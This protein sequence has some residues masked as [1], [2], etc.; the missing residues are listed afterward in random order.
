MPF[1]DIDGASLEYAWI[2]GG[3]AA[4]PTIVFLHEGLGC[5][6]MWR[7]FPRRL[8]E[9][10]ACPALVYSRP[11]YGRSSGRLQRRGTDYLHIEALVVLP[12]VLAA[13]E[14]GEYLLF[15]HSDGASIALLHAASAA[16]PATGLIIEAPH[17]FV[18]DITLTGIRAAGE[19]YRGG[20][21]TWRN[22]LTRYHGAR[23]D[24]VFDAWHDVWL[25]PAFG[26]WN[27]EAELARI[28]CP[29]LLLQGEED[30]YG[31]RCQLDS[32]AER[33]D[34]PCETHL[35][36]DC[37]HVAHR[38]ASERVSQ[39]ALSFIRRLRCAL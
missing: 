26:D 16:V 11:G 5:V 34:G 3:D 12:R 30:E 13:L 23:T 39:L 19:A 21:G 33:T 8:A 36:P 4:A 31:S 38:D 10:S 17:V 25:N 6:E 27:I 35:L 24:E 29:I 15:G 9:L 32:I 7:D 2:D 22:R 20:D 37:G 18:E 1:V 14:V 28:N